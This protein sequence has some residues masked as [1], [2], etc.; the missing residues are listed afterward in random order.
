MTKEE[1]DSKQNSLKK[2]YNYMPTGVPGQVKKVEVTEEDGEDKDGKEE[3]GE[4]IITDKHKSDWNK[5]LTWLDTKKMRGKPELDKSGLGNQLFGQYIKENPTT[6]LSANIIPGIRKEYK[7]LRQSG[8]DDIMKGS[9]YYLGKTGKGADTSS[10]MKHIELNEQSK[11]PNY[12]GQHLTQ[13]YF[14]DAK[15]GDEE[16]VRY[17]IKEKESLLNK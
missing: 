14:P 5:Y 13:T 4:P 3:E 10:F 8:I 17:N 16:A 12:V 7:K 2:S 6:S 1:W 9:A 11:D 15:I